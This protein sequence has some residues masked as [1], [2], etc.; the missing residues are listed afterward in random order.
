MGFL[1]KSLGAAEERESIQNQPGKQCHMTNK[2]VDF[3][4]RQNWVRNP[5]GPLREDIQ[6]PR[7]LLAVK[8]LAET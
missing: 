2:I 5:A 3:E 1:V 8:G 6:P 4:I 7:P